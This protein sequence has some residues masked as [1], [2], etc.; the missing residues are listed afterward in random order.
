MKKVFLITLVFALLAGCGSTPATPP[1]TEAPAPTE[2]PVPAATDAPIP[3]F[4]PTMEPV[5]NM[6][7]IPAGEFQMGCDPDNNGGFSC[8][9]NELPLHTVNLDDY[10]IDIYEVTNAQYAECV[11]DGVCDP[12]HD[13]SS[14]TQ[15][16]YYDNPIFA[17]FPVI[18]VNWK[19]ADAY[20]SWAGK[21]LPTEAEWEKAARGT[22][23]R[24]YPW[25]DGD[26]SC[27]LANISD[28]S[29]SNDCVG[30]TV[31]VGSYPEGASYYGVMDMT[32]NVWEWVS[33]W[34]SES[35]YGTSLLDN[36]TG[37]D[38]EA[39]KVLRGGGWSN[40]WLYQR[41][42]GRT[43]DPNFNNSEDVGF[44]CVSTAPGD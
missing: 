18:Y 5:N 30:D 9:A 39:N 4:P 12:P 25:G 26:P 17:S 7:L 3:T 23:V 22:T 2:N 13:L 37:P 6:M 42:A 34:Y 31:E 15:A 35:Y 38:G 28:D 14:S 40:S 24:T 21:R 10:Y 44:R 19:D 27:S 29:G 16:S 11:Q 20:C 8:L 32:G 33:D 43:F 36:P 1:P 41:T